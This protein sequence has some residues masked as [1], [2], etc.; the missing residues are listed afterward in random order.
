[1]PCKSC[2]PH[3]FCT[4]DPSLIAHHSHGGATSSKSDMQALH[5]MVVKKLADWKSGLPV[6][7]L[8]DLHDRNALYLPHVLLLQYEL[9][10]FSKKLMLT[11]GI[12]HA[13]LSESYPHSSPVDV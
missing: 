8:V 13:V 10:P 3:Y 11:N 1:M 6:E 4:V 12:Q 9:I 5:A 7:L 2:S